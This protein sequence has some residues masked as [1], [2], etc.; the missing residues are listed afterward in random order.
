[1]MIEEAVNCERCGEELKPDRV[2]WLEF[3]QRTSTYVDPE[4]V[5]VPDDDSQGLFA[6]GRSC[7][8]T[9]LQNEG[10]ADW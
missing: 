8:R 4:Q 9:V 7:A 6:F 2:S 1:M 10:E 5:A 3:D